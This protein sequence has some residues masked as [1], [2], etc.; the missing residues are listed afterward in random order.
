V[1]K[2]S[3]G[4]EIGLVHEYITDTE[5]LKTNTYELLEKCLLGLGKRND[6]NGPF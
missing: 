6:V 5:P 1:T 2:D 3:C 4:V